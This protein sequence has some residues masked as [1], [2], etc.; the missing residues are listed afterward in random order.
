MCTI[1][2]KAGDKGCVIRGNSC[3]LKILGNATVKTAPQKRACCRRAGRVHD[4]VGERCGDTGRIHDAT[5]MPRSLADARRLGVRVAVAKCEA[6]EAH[7]RRAADKNAPHG[8][9]TT[10]WLRLDRGRGRRTVDERL[11]SAFYANVS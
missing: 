10:S 5:A 8:R 7:N 6:F 3:V 4:A 2:K 11:G 9:R 1:L